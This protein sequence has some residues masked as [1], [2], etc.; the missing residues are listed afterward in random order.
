MVK[1]FDPRLSVLA[2]VPIPLFVLIISLVGAY[3]FS[4]KISLAQNSYLD[5]LSLLFFICF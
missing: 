3:I 5:M 2:L 4:F 1:N